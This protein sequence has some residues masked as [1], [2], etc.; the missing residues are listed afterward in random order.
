TAAGEDRVNQRTLNGELVDFVHQELARQRSAEL[1]PADRPAV[2]EV[3]G[4]VGILERKLAVRAEVRLNAEAPVIV[5]RA[6]EVE[7][8]TGG[9]EARVQIVVHVVLVTEVG[10]VAELQRSTHLE[11]ETLGGQEEVAI[12]PAVSAGQQA[13]P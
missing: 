13:R 1:A 5:H 4:A 8:G 12:V 9:F 3:V 2:A 7:A 10:D 6:V 11:A